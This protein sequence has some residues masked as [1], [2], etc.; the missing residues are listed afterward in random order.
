[1]VNATITLSAVFGANGPNRLTRVTHVIDRIMKIIVLTPRGRITDLMRKRRRKMRKKN[2]ERERD[3]DTE[4]E[5]KER[6]G[7]EG[8]AC[9]NVFGFSPVSVLSQRPQRQVL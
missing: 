3:R 1:M 5:E 4:K 9:V 8:R 2:E 6:E 7:R